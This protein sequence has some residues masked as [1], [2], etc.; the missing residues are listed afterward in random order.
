VAIGVGYD[1][2][3]TQALPRSHDGPSQPRRVREDRTARHLHGD[4]R[5]IEL[6]LGH[7][8]SRPADDGSDR[9]TGGSMKGLPTIVVTG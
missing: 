2:S 1:Q 4:R 9:A 8:L 7:R 3:R 5:R 6:G